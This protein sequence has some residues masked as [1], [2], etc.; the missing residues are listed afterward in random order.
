MHESLSQQ[1]RIFLIAGN[2]EGIVFLLGGGSA[3]YL[4]CLSEHGTLVALILL[5]IL[6]SSLPVLV[7]L[8]LVEESAGFVGGTQVPGDGLHSLE[9][10]EGE[11]AQAVHFVCCG[12]EEG[13]GE[14]ECP[15]DHVEHGQEELVFVDVLVVPDVHF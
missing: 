3:F 1:F 8:G 10:E 2:D 4:F 11:D 15:V 5:S 6:A 13:T 7:F 14:H 9:G 12:E